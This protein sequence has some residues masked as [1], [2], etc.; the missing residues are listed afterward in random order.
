MPP[1]PPRGSSSDAVCFASE[2]NLAELMSILSA[3]YDPIT[4]SLY[5]L[6]QSRDKLGPGVRGRGGVAESTADDRDDGRCDPSALA[7]DE[8]ALPRSS[9]SVVV[10]LLLRAANLCLLLDACPKLGAS[11]AFAQ[12]AQ[13]P[14]YVSFRH[15]LRHSINMAYHCLFWLAANE[16]GALIGGEPPR[17]PSEFT[18]YQQHLFQYSVALFACL[19]AKAIASPS[20]HAVEGPLSNTAC[21]RSGSPSNAPPTPTSGGST[22]SNTG[23][24][25]GSS[26]TSSSQAAGAAH[27][28]LSLCVAFWVDAMLKCV[29]P[30]Q[31]DAQHQ[32]HH[33]HQDLAHMSAVASAKAVWAVARTPQLF[34]AIVLTLSPNVDPAVIAAARRYLEAFQLLEMSGVGGTSAPTSANVSF[35]SGGAVAAES[36]MLHV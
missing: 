21:G 33:Y 9:I 11:A 25:G 12:V 30:L 4:A 6:L 31:A 7:V 3:A 36:R 28:Q 15:L 16:H 17:S 27:H 5:A 14:G 13:R 35:G 22:G 29:A 10:A 18:P 23:P 1:S 32:S 34:Q 20:T 26:V 24:S 8:F 19:S 2:H